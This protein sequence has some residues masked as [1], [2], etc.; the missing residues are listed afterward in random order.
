MPGAV[1]ATFWGAAG[2][3]IDV[4]PQ[5]ADDTVIFDPVSAKVRFIRVYRG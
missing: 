2:D 4:T 5:S 1:T 3:V